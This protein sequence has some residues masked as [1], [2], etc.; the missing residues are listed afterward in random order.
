[1]GDS[2]ETTEQSAADVVIVDYGAFTNYLRKI[3]TIFFEE[4]LVSGLK[5]F[6]LIFLAYFWFMYKDLLVSFQAEQG[7]DRK[8]QEKL[9]TYRCFCSGFFDWFLF[10]RF[11][12][13][14][15]NFLRSELP[16]N[17]SKSSF[18]IPRCSLCMFNVA[19]PKV[20]NKTLKT[21]SAYKS[22]MNKMAARPL[23]CVL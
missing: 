11:L 9:A 19:I 1:M 22:W 7:F 21:N 17:A 15:F 18:P 16:K 12:Q 8:V 14:L 3:I 4:D 6:L 5:Y 13:F 23:L 2:L 10:F 20:S